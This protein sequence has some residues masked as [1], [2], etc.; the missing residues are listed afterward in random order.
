MNTLTVIII[1]FLSGFVIGYITKD[2][3]TIEKQVQVNIK[4]Q[5]VKG[6]N[7]VLDAV[8]DVEVQEE[9]KNKGLFKWFKN[10]K[11]RRNREK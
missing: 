5:K 2:L 4:K 7:N 9:E 6:E 1:S 8:V 10:R 3:L 11:L